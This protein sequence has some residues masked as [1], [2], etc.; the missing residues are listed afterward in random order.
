M[1]KKTQVG[2]SRMLAPTE[3]RLIEKK[4]RGTYLHYYPRGALI[5]HSDI[6]DC[7]GVFFSLP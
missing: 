6:L 2:Q 5:S 4:S 1:G 7:V 3:Y